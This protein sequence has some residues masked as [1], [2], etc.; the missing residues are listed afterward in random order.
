LLFSAPKIALYSLPHYRFATKSE[1]LIVLRQRRSRHWSIELGLAALSGLVLLS[2]LAIVVRACIVHIGDRRLAA[3]MA[4]LD[5]SEPGWRWEDVLGRREVIP[6]DENSAAIVLA[7]TSLFPPNWPQNSAASPRKQQP[8]A[9]TVRSLLDRL[10]ELEPVCALDAERAADLRAE[11]VQLAPALAEAHKLIERPK[12]RYTVQWAKDFL[13]T[14]L[15]HAMQARRCARLLS[16]DAAMRAHDRDCDGALASCRGELNA[17][18]SIGDEP[19]IVSQLVRMA[20]GT[21]AALDMERVLAQ[22]Q[23]SQEALSCASAGLADEASQNLWLIAARGERA[24]APGVMNAFLTAELDVAQ[25]SS[26]HY[27]PSQKANPFRWLFVRPIMHTGDAT[28]LQY[29]TTFVEAAEM[30]VGIRRAQVEAVQQEIRDIMSEHNMSMASVVFLAGSQNRVADAYE[31]NLAHLSC[32]QVGIALERYRVANGHWPE[33]LDELV[34]KLLTGI[35]E[36]PFAPETLKYRRLQDGVVAYSVGLD[37]ED[38]GGVLSRH[39]PKIPKID[40]GF[41]LWDPAA[42]RAPPPAQ[43]TG[44]EEHDK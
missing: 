30:P 16:L 15:D 22:G 36:D 1:K 40:I 2:I 27:G 33:T 20:C 43:P 34:P 25:L 7:A 37:K 41:R 24:A 29:M 12:G 31:C 19:A 9:G 17:G 3:A 44:A 23:A 21:F 18:R 8:Q 28:A 32:A 6:D 5:D 35:P 11:L 13:S 4:E 39:N 38:N 42:R 14:R 10:E 26:G